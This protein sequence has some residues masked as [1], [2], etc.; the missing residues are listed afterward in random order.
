MVRGIR[1]PVE[2]PPVYP[3]PEQVDGGW[4]RTEV[5]TAQGKGMRGDETMG[6]SLLRAGTS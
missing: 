6:P 5:G 4:L 1:F 3:F 2:S